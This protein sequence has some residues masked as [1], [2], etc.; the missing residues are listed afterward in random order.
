MIKVNFL[1][2]LGSDAEVVTTGST[3]FISFRA[4][5]DESVNKEKTTRW[6]SVNADQIRFKNLSQY[7]TKGKLVY[8]TGNEKVTA[9]LS[10]TGDACVD[11]R[12]WADSIEFVSIG[13]K[14]ETTE[15]S[16]SKDEK[17]NQLTAGT[18]K[19]KKNNKVEEKTVV[20]ES[21]SS[22]DDEL[23]F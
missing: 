21:S 5:I 23:P 19:S 7:L 9:Y 10:K 17:N 1:G 13:Q 4:A 16:F 20:T 18:L 3:Q 14:Q 12:I 8:V 22:D 15:E 6:V 2:R 11:T